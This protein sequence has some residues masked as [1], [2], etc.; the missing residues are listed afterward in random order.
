MKTRSFFSGFALG[1]LV[2][3][4]ELFVVNPL[5]STAVASRSLLFSTSPSATT[6]DG[7]GKSPMEHSSFDTAVLNR[8]ACKK[9]QRF[10]G[11][12]SAGS[13]SSATQSDP[14]VVQQALECLDLARRTPTAFNTQPYKVVLVHSPE[15]KLALSKYCLGPNGGRVRDSDCTAI[16]LA[17][18][19]VFRTLSRFRQFLNA[20]RQ[21]N[22]TPPSRKDLFVLQ[23]YITLFSSG[24]PL[25][26]FLSAIMSFAVRTCVAI[27]NLFT[28]WFY[29]LPSLASAETWSSK[30]TAMVAITYILGCTSLGLATIP[31]EGINARGIRKVIGAPSRYAVPLIVSTGRPYKNGKENK[32][33]TTSRYPLDEVV[34]DNSFGSPIVQALAPAS[35]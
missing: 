24:Y 4:E 2:L 18:R 11:A 22:R 7:R 31:M 27:L 28:S 33:S 13:E 29:P 17:D 25:P 19:Q 21:P 14:T 15:Q 12:E 34:Y 20:T 6:E 30:Q 10:D 23:F 8:Y 5:V 32:K 1:L 35:A 26:R 9:F 16:F 3:G